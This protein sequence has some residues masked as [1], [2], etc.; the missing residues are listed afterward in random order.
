MCHVFATLLH[1]FAIRTSINQPTALVA[2]YAYGVVTWTT[3]L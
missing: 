3:V 1:M 2:T